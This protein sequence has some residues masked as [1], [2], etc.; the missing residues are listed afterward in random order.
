MEIKRIMLLAFFA[1]TLPINAAAQTSEEVNEANNPLTPK[2]TVN[3]QDQYVGSYYG[4]RDS[5]SN[6]FLV[7]GVL[8][9]KLFGLPQILRATIPIV[10]SP[11]PRSTT[12]LGDINMFNLFLFKAGGVELGFG[13]QLTMASAT[14]DRLGTGRWQLGAA[15]VVIS[16]FSWG[17]LGGLVTYQHSVDSHDTRPT[18]NNLSSQPFVIYNLPEGFYLRSTATW[19]FDLQRGNFY[20]PLGFGAGKVWKL[21]NGTTLNLFAEPQVTVAHDGVAPKFQLFSGLNMQFPIGH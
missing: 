3:L 2:I 4:L 6:S 1:L 16:P 10:T 11:D 13:P 7:R 5:D 8:P 12:G 21:E 18:Q 19:N 9:H 15:G 17:L 20:I 14:K